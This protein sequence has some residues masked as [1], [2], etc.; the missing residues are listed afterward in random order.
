MD[1]QRQEADRQDQRRNRK[2]NTWIL[3]FGVLATVGTL[4]VTTLTLRSGQEQLALAREGQ[5]T[6]R[7]ANAVGLLSSEQR[8]VRTAAV[9][10]LERIAADSPR[11]ALT[12]R[13]VLASF[14]RQ[15]AS[16]IAAGGKVPQGPETDVHAAL[17]FLGRNRAHAGDLPVLDLRGIRLRIDL[18]GDDLDLREANL[19]E[20]DLRESDLSG[21]N[22]ARAR[23]GGADLRETL[24]IAANLSGV[25][26]YSADLRGA[27]LV[28][29]DLRGAKLATVL[30]ESN[31]KEAPFAADLRGTD[32]RGADLR[33]VQGMSE[34]E[35]RR[36][37]KTDESTR[38][39]P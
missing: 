1:L 14:V 4:L 34:A 10:A 36:V 3:A 20:A 15:H 16:A 39:D 6:D 31:S 7:Y 5:V 37:A 28:R 33:G 30:P 25:S 19:L 13:K 12:I 2:F 17:T 9:Y 35:I 22:L 27:I 8:G 29:A 18:N 32:L 38:F 23:L 21:T 11:D 24:L 26:L